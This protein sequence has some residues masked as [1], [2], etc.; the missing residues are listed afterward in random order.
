MTGKR[1]LYHLAVVKN[2]PWQYHK[3]TISPED[4][5]NP[6]TT[7]HGSKFSSQPHT[8]QQE[9]INSSPFRLKPV[10][11]PPEKPVKAPQVNPPVKPPCNSPFSRSALG[12]TRKEIFLMQCCGLSS[13]VGISL[14]VR[15]VTRPSAA[16]LMNYANI[17]MM[18]SYSNSKPHHSR[19]GRRGRR[20]RKRA[21]ERKSSMMI[22]LGSSRAFTLH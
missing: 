4:P 15:G 13:D 12:T 2:V 17:D 9:L 14:S 8:V 20:E 16:A 10:S 6:I 11:N 1:K 7:H 18:R 22:D 3:S 19:G 21:S 5:K